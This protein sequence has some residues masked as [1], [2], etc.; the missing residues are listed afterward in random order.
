MQKGMKKMSKDFV[1][2]LDI[3]TTS[4]KA[5]LFNRVGR[6]IAES[7]KGYPISHPK[8]SWAEQDPYEIERAAIAAIKEALEKSKTLPTELLGLGISSAMHSLICVDKEGDA[9]SPSIIWADGRSV[10]QANYVKQNHS[11][12]Y[13]KTGTPIHPMSPFIKL[14]WMKETNYEPYHTAAKFTSIKEFLLH[15]WFGTNDVDYS[16]AAATGLFNV[17]TFEWEESALELAGITREQLSTPVPPTKIIQGMD[18]QIAEKM[19]IPHDLPFVIGASDGPLAN[20]GNGAIDVGDV[21]VTIGT[22]GAIR[23]M[24]SKPQLDQHQEIFCYTFTKDLWIMGGP[25]NNGAIVLQ[26]LKDVMGQE[27]TDRAS[28]E[29]VNPYELLTETASAA[30]LGSDGLLFL[31]FLNGERAPYWDSNARGSYI[32]LTLAHQKKHLLRAALE[33]VI[34]SLY[35]VGESLE[36]LAGEPTKLYASG[37][38][39]RSTL[40]L[41]ILS[42]VFGKRVEVPQ[43]HQS[44]AWGVAWMTLFALGEVESLSSIKKHIP[45]QDSYT[46]LKHSHELYQELF[47]IYRSLYY[48]LESQFTSL[49]DFQRRIK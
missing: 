17:Y 20:L 37:G 38:F 1:I 6:V 30:R 44:S 34:F 28:K 9:L 12:I 10:A 33:G 5:V 47:R 22:S 36:R 41:E 11:N 19:G 18:K 35:S 16:I 23:Q 7:E 25:T 3:G 40:W 48:S 14:I 43:S 24:S 13:A 42:N 32:G 46:P 39:A 29:G 15:R 26:W 45:M 2:G 8:A 27:E 49:S 31:P 4:A 21:A